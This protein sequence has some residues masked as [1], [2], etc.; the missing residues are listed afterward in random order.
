[1]HLGLLSEIF[2]TFDSLM[3]ANSNN[4]MNDDN[5]KHNL[6]NST[7]RDDDKNMNYASRD[8]EKKINSTSR[9]YEININII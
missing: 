7:S 4:F 3:N 5:I 1:M 6:N 8:D 2:C 9:N